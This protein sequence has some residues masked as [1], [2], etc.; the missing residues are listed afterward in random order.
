MT[1]PLHERMEAALAG[2]SAQQEKLRALEKR[3]GDTS[4]TAHGKNRMMSATVDHSGR[5][6]ALVFEGTR[7]RSM[8]PKELA[9]AIVETIQQAQRDAQAQGFAAARE[10]MP[11]TFDL[12]G[13]SAPVVEEGRDRPRRRGKQNEPPPAPQLDFEKVFEA[14]A[15]MFEQ[16]L[17][18]TDHS[19]TT[20]SDGSA[21]R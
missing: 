3:V 19:G 17:L 13:L 2:F 1:T 15:R 4:A 16:P 21:Q 14:A 5:L 7:F 12:L 6:T 10:F 20:T 8:A 9:A 18:Q 11:D